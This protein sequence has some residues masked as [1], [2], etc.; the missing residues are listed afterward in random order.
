M[1]L[2]YTPKTLAHKNRRSAAIFIRIFKILYFWIA[3]SLLYVPDYTIGFGGFRDMGIN[4]SHKKFGEALPRHRG[5]QKNKHRVHNN[6]V[7]NICVTFLGSSVCSTPLGFACV[8]QCADVCGAFFYPFLGTRER[9]CAFFRFDLEL[10]RSI[11][12]AG[13]AF[14]SGPSV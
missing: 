2:F 4:F 5:I 13:R 3:L 11:S 10:I 7:T 1:G 8:R 6:R 9:F 12:V 14:D